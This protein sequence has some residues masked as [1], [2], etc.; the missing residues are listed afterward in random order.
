MARPL[1]AIDG[2]ADP[3][4]QFAQPM[5]GSCESAESGELGADLARRCA[6]L[7]VYGGPF[8]EAVVRG[9]VAS[10]SRWHGLS[11]SISPAQSG[12]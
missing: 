2:D 5:K 11:D 7:H 1:F 9:F 10:V 4:P 3:T 6:S 8:I 12:I